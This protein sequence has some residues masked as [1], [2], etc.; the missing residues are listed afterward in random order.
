MNAPLSHAVKVLTE[1]LEQFLSPDDDP[2]MFNLNQ[3]LRGVAEG[4]ATLEDRI[5]HLEA[6]VHNLDK[7]A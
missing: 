7:R 1:N 6:T 2:V 3:A 4:I 5:R